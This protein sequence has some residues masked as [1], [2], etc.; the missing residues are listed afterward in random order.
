MQRTHTPFSSHHTR[1]S[2]CAFTRQAHRSAQCDPSRSSRS[3]R[4]G[5]CVCEHASMRIRSCKHARTYTRLC[6]CTHLLHSRIS[7][8]LAQYKHTQPSPAFT[9]SARTQP[10]IT[11]SLS[12]KHKHTQY[13][14]TGRSTQQ[15][16]TCLAHSGHAVCS[17]HARVQPAPL[18]VHDA[19]AGAVCR[20]PAHA[21]GCGACECVRACVPLFLLTLLSITECQCTADCTHTSVTA[22]NHL[23]C[24]LLTGCDELRHAGGLPG[25][26]DPC[27]LPV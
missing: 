12:H 16:S 19:A 6:V 26:P 13:H 21:E 8:T 2:V 3:T 20:A 23:A 4:A 1:P 5:G 7:P 14:N 17:G 15:P 10:H 24:T 11:L 9:R 22:L 18:C 27:W 25:R